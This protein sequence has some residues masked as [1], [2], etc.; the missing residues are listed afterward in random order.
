MFAVAAGGIAVAPSLKTN[1]GLTMKDMKH[2]IEFKGL[3]L[4]TALAVT[5][6]AGASANIVYTV[7]QT[8]GAGSDRHPELIRL[9][10]LEPQ[11]ERAR[12]I[13]DDHESRLRRSR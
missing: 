6:A 13:D 3:V 5:S 7:N 4:G 2:G 11:A 12:R 1:R 10:C 9:S 8:I